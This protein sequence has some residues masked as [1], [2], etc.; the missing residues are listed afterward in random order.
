MNYVDY[1]TTAYSSTMYNAQQRWTIALQ[2]IQAGTYTADKWV[3]DVLGTWLDG[4]QPV[5]NSWGVAANVP[6]PVVGFNV[7]HGTGLTQTA[8]T[9]ILPPLG[10]PP[11]VHVTDVRRI[12]GSEK[13]IG[14]T[15]A[16]ATLTG[17]LLK[18]ELKNLASLPV[19]DY[20]GA[21]YLG[22]TVNRTVALVYLVVS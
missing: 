16:T 18:V 21:V 8:L 22:G 13:V 15:D 17:G 10:T 2:Q 4:A 20:E 9:N 5:W 3:N 1:L 7:P 14:D 6:V 12:G 11:A 19:G